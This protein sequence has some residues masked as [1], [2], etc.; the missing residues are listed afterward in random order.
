[1]F[2]DFPTFSRICIFFLLTLSLL[3][4]S[5]LIFL[6]SL[7][8][9]CSAFHLSMSEVWLLNFLRQCTNRANSHQCAVMHYKCGL[10]IFG[11]GS[12]MIGNAPTMF[13]AV[14]ATAAFFHNQ[15]PNRSH[16]IIWPYDRKSKNRQAWRVHSLMDR[17][18]DTPNL[19]W[20]VYEAWELT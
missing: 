20:S 4:F 16:L 17:L 11:E 15:A 2:R 10:V 18:D 5:L 9:P 1:M 3:S 19:S 7:A 12:N 13:S 14:V 6:F 8:L